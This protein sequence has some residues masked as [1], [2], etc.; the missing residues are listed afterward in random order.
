MRSANRRWTIAGIAFLALVAVVPVTAALRSDSASAAPALPGD[1]TSSA[2]AGASCWG[3][4]QQ[5]PASASGT[6]WLLTKS[7]DR[8]A[9]FACDMTTD[10]GGWVLVARGRNG[11]TFSPNGQGSAATVRTTTDGTGAFA[12]ASLDTATIDGLLDKGA[13]SALADGIR[14]E[15]ATNTDG[16]NRQDYRLYPRSRSWTWN[17]GAGQLLNKVT[18]NGTTYN[19]SNTADT[20]AGATGQATNGLSGAQDT[21]RMYTFA[22]TGHNN[23]MGFGFGNQVGGGSN[24]STNYLWTAASE[25]SPLAFTKVWV[26]PRIAND[27]AGFTPIPAAGYPAEAK[28]LSLK[29]RSEVAP[30]GVS[31]Y[32][33]DN[34]DTVTPWK[35]NVMVIKAYGDRVY[36]GGRFTGVQNGPSATPIAQG[37]IA[38]FDLDGNWISTFRPNVAGRVWDM[39]LTD[40]GKLIIGGDFTSVDGLAD[41]SG[42]AALD[43]ATGKVITTWKGSVTRTGTT[44]RAIVRSLATKGDWVYAGGR[45]NSVKGGT[46]PVTTTTNA[47]NLKTSNGNPGSWRP[48]IYAAAVR[49]LVSAAGDRVYMAGYFNAVNDD[50]NHGY[51]G[52]TNPTNGAVIPGLGPWQPSTTG[53]KYQQAVAENGDNILVGGSEHDFQMY[54]HNRNTL[55]DS[56]ITKQ[57]G[58]TQAIEKVGNYIYFS[59]HCMNWVY[60]G[61]NNW[62]NPTGFRAVD[63]IRMVGRVDATTFDYDTTWYPNGTK[64]INDEGI[65]SITSDKRDC[66]WVGGDLVRGAYS[67]NAATDYLGGFARFCP[68]DAVVPTTPTNLK[69]TVA[70]GSVDLS[71]TASTDASG[72]PSYDVYR[73][74]RVIATVFGTTFSD[75]TANGSSGAHQYTV[76]AADARGNRS[77]SPAPIAVNGPAPEI[78]TP[79]AYGATWKYVDS[80][81]DLG[82]AWRSGTF[83]DSVGLRP[84]PARLGRHP[85]HHPRRRH[86]ARH[87][88]PPQLVH[89]RRPVPGQGPRPR[90]QAGPGRGGLRERRRG[91]PGEHAQRGGHL[92]HPRL[93]VHERRRGRHGQG[94]PG[95]RQHPQGRCQQHR[96]GAARLEG[97]RHQ[98]VLRPAGHQPGLEHRHHGAHQAHGHGHG[99]CRRRGP[100]LDPVHRRPEP[101]RLRGRP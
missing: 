75:T 67:G 78:A 63:P 97:Q 29:N 79:I 92:R 77:A 9:Q 17:L 2:T 68:T 70:S 61:T 91:R 64:G 98:G 13:P 69:A 100:H 22:W 56:T 99:R 25:G 65:W 39:V 14:L 11:W 41:T 88:L 54:D 10:G 24:A 21:R 3:I 35:D 49:L 48:R 50:T 86:Q 37:S 76:R 73:D 31:G 59:C 27:A 80:G 15:R 66:L 72:T 43:P 81:A 30:W 38:A 12:P 85:G 52:I 7:M 36:V 74:D 93:G 82:T 83:D 32:N 23:Q 96:R 28:P 45:F 84:G 40:D 6:F 8:P 62:T 33:H 58:D 51:Y 87:H 26:R 5:Y 20:A 94:H 44:A 101:R 95:P 53:S 55:I 18:V 90:G 57:G 89:R 4:K 60:Q 19:G 46:Y 1:G 34:E 16:S 71:W 42:M 47:I